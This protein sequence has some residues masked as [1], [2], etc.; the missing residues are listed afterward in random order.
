V[1]VVRARPKRARTLFAPPAIN[2]G[3]TLADFADDI[4][5]H[6]KA[7]GSYDAGCYEYH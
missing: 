5:G 2:A 6:P 4:E 7:T 1:S 3:T